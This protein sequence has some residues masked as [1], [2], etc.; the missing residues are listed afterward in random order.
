MQAVYISLAQNHF[1]GSL[2][3][4]LPKAAVLDMS[5][6][7]L[8][9]ANFANLPAALQLLY[10]GNNTLTGSLPQALARQTSLP[11]N[12]TILD[13]SHNSLSGSLP[14]VL[15]SNMSVLNISDNAFTGSLPGDWSILQQMTVLKADNNPLISGRLPASWS[16]WG[17]S[18]GNSLQLSI[19]NTSLHGRMPR[20]W[21]QQF[22][23]AVNKSAQART[24]FRPILLGNLRDDEADIL[25]A[26]PLI[27]LP[28]QNASIMV[29][30]GGKAYIFDYGNPASICSIPNA[31]R[32]VALVWGLFVAVILTAIVGCVLW[33][34]RQATSKEGV[35]SKLK[36]RGVD[37]LSTLTS[38]VSAEKRLLMLGLAHRA[39]YLAVDVTW[40]LYSQITDA[41]TIHQVF[42]SGQLFYAYALL[43]ILLLPFAFMLLLVARISVISFQDRIGG[44]TWRR[45]VAI[46]VGLIVSPGLLVVLEFAMI[47]HGLG[48]PLP[49]W[50]RAFG[51]DM[52][53]FYRVQ[54][55]AEALVN[56]LPQ[57]IVQSKLYLMGNDPN[58]VHVYI[59]TTLF[60]FSMSGSLLSI[61]KSIPLVM[62]EHRYFKCSV[63]AYFIR[64]MRLEPLGGHKGLGEVSTTNRPSTARTLV[65]QASTHSDQG[66]MSQASTD[67]ALV[68][69]LDIQLQRQFSS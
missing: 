67:K 19:T 49:M 9:E 16:T 62:L 66:L 15:P 34:R 41:V 21:V 18:T 13:V 11:A 57:S 37:R 55:L 53:S 42:G 14:A 69:P 20:P 51:V 3:E 12:L 24:L 10:V 36:Q 63:K 6:N 25:S 4:G 35:L 8:S 61:L 26:G 52:F 65:S 59:D 48:V 22:C 43:V 31:V 44:K 28:A 5:S 64:S 38:F 1:Q 54:S 32:N 40:N 56:A 2:P 7:Q 17:N 23:L 27:E 46:V 29:T 60:L 45:A 39:W 68:V 30:L 47:L 50:V 33:H 58:G